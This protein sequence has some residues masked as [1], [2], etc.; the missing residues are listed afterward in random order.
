MTKQGGLVAVAG[1][2]F[3]DWVLKNSTGGKEMFTSKASRIGKAGWEV[4]MKG[5]K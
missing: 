4:K 1:R 5:F 2:S 3:F